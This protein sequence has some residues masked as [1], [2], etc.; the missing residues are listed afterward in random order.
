MDEYVY[1]QTEYL[2]RVFSIIE[3]SNEDEIRAYLKRNE[4]SSY[5]WC[6]RFKVPIFSRRC[7]LIEASQ[8]D[9]QASFPQ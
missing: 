9:P 5:E 1:T 4:R 8:S 3:S 2:E 6:V 7:R